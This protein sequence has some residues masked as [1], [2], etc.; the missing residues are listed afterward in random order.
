MFLLKKIHSFQFLL[1]ESSWLVHSCYG[2]TIFGQGKGVGG[3]F[4]TFG[5]YQQP[6][7]FNVIFEGLLFSDIYG[8]S[9]GQNYFG[10]RSLAIMVTKF[11]PFF[12]F[13]WYDIEHFYHKHY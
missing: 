8:S 4:I 2:P 3:G 12:S 6:Q 1:E 5:T 7:F 13:P 10:S 11:I 9:G